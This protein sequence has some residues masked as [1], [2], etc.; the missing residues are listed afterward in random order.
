MA[1]TPCILGQA[2]P[3]PDTE[4]TLFCVPAAS[5]VQCSIFVSNHSDT[6]EYISI[7]LVPNGSGEAAYSYIAWN[8]PMSKNAC[9]A[10][11][12]IFLNTNDTVRISSKFGNASFTATGMLMS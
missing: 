8:T 10:F 9:I 7:A 11:A 3:K 12:G 2:Y 1:E 4:I 6:V 5:Q